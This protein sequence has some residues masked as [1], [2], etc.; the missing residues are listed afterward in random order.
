MR[1]RPAQGQGLGD[2][3]L[4]RRADPAGDAGDRRKPRAEDPG[5]A[6]V[7]DPQKDGPAVKAGIEAGDVITAVDDKPVLD[8]RDLARKIGG[9]PPGATRQARRCPQGRAQRSSRSRSANCRMC[10]MP[11]PSSEMPDREGRG[12]VQQSGP[13]AGARRQG[14]RRGGDRSRPIEARR[15]ISAS[16]RATSFSRLAARRWQRRRRCD[17]RCAAPAPRQAKRFV[18]R[19]V[20]ARRRGSWRYR[21]AVPEQR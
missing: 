13:V 20:G 17:A 6:L 7:A 8:A 3:W 5:G 10:A 14:A 15:L 4:D 19:E 9:M 11:A 16:S 2:P 21:S 12:D 1:R 18:A